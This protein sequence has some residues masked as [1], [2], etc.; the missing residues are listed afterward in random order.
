MYMDYLNSC[1]VKQQ[2]EKEQREGKKDE[3]VN[4]QICIN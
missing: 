4:Q 3:Q 2:E 1:S